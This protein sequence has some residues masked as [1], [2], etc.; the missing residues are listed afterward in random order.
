M[1]KV[2]YALTVILL[3]SILTIV[4]AGTSFAQ[5]SI[6]DDG[7]LGFRLPYSHYRNDEAIE[8]YGYLHPFVEGQ[9][10]LV[11]VYR[12]DG[13]LY[14]SDTGTPQLSDP[15]HGNGEFKYSFTIKEKETVSEYYKI[16][17]SYGNR[18]VESIFFYDNEPNPSISSPY[19]LKWKEKEYAIEFEIDGDRD[20]TELRAC[21]DACDGG[22]SIFLV[23]DQKRSDIKLKI[24]VPM[25]LINKVFGYSITPT[26]TTQYREP[27]YGTS[28]DI[29]TA[30]F[31]DEPSYGTFD[32]EPELYLTPVDVRCESVTW[33]M[34]VPSYARRIDLSFNGYGFILEAV[35]YPALDNKFPFR[36]NVTIAD[37]TFTLNVLTNAKSC[38]FDFNKEDKRLHVD[39][40]T[41]DEEEKGYFSI[42]MP[43]RLLGG[44]YSV[45]VDNKK[46]NFTILGTTE[47]FS[48][49][50]GRTEVFTVMELEYDK[51]AKSIDIIGTTVIPEF[52][53]TA[54]TIFS[55]VVLLAVITRL[56]PKLSHSND[57]TNK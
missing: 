35:P 3:I 37:E 51:K 21:V 28:Y 55:G 48:K 32:D 16:V 46:A 45:L 15:Y 14:L 18:M 22:D 23:L 30:S 49:L 50:I 34:D 7:W 27:W 12:N 42:N 8:P 11:H 57:L 43:Q 1:I 47:E 20:V 26:Y 2:A 40:A 5:E 29:I 25:S 56:M 52:P 9:K 53:R 4:N 38:N 33:E 24:T 39:I 44:N 41:I 31:S 6:N 17:I 36:T 10:Y 13:S 54:L 19:L